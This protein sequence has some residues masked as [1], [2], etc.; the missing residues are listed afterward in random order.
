[1]EK[2]I[3]N[4]NDEV[5]LYCQSSKRAKK[6]VSINNKFTQ[7]FEEALEK[8]KLGLRK[9]G[10]VKRYDKVLEKIGRLRERYSIVSKYYEIKVEKDEKSENA[11]NIIYKRK[12][13]GNNKD[14]FPGVYCLRTSHKELDEKTLWKTY[15]MLTELESVFRTLKSELGMRP[16]YH[17]IEKRI[18]GH[19]FITVIAYHLVHTIR[20]RLKEKGINS[21][22]SSLLRQLEGQ[23]RITVSMKCRDNKILHIR[24][25][26]YPEQRQQKI[27]DAL[28]LKY[29]PGK[30]IKTI[31]KERT[32]VVP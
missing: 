17:R 21:S 25:S 15:T 12:G 9:K 19:L 7:R 6:E 24:K 10:Y 27:Y 4:K 28:N 23:N 1:V 14:S 18:K 26:S 11:I 16:I 20:Y 29:L 8:V 31:I 2:V 32:K 13:S 22:W 30:M 5:L 3:D